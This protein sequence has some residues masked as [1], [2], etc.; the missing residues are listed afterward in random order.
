MKFSLSPFRSGK[1]L[2]T[3]AIRIILVACTLSFCYTSPSQAQSLRSK[4]DGNDKYGYVEE[5]STQ[6]VIPPIYDFAYSFL[7]MNNPVAL[8]RYQ[9]KYG[10]INTSGGFVIQP[11]Y[12]DATSFF[13]GIAIVKEGDT[14]YAIDLN[15]K[16]ISPDFADLKRS[17][18]LYW[19]KESDGSYYILDANFN[20]ISNRK[21]ESLALSNMQL[22]G[23]P[24]REVFF[25]WFSENGKKG[26]CDVKGN[27]V[28]PA[29]YSELHT[30]DY[31]YA[32]GYKKCDK[33]NIT[34]DHFQWI[35]KAKDASTGKFGV[36]DL[37]GNT[38]VP[39]TFKDSYKLYKGTSRYY[40]KAFLPLFT[41][42]FET[43]KQSVADRLIPPYTEIATANSQLAEV[44]P[45]T[46]E[47][48]SVSGEILAVKELK[49]A[50]SSKKQS[51]GKGQKSSDETKSTGR[52]AFFNGDQQ[53][54]TAYTEIIPLGFSYL[55][56]DT[57]GKMGIADAMGTEIV[58][59]EYDDI[60]I[61]R[62][63]ED[64][65]HIL[66]AQKGEESGLMSVSGSILTPIE[67]SSIFL[68][69]NQTGVA[70]KEGKYFLINAATGKVVSSRGYDDIDNYTSND[71]I[72]AK[73]AGFTTTLSADGQENPRIVDQAFQIAYDTPDQE[74]QQKYDRYMLC[75][76][77]CESNS[78][79]GTVLNNVG[80]LYMTLND[81]E[82]AIAYYQKAQALGNANA[83]ENLKNINRARRLEMIQQI[84]QAI[85]EVGQAISANSGM[86]PIN[87]NN[88]YTAAAYAADNGDVQTVSSA[89][90]NNKLPYETY[91]SIYDRWERNAKSCYESLTLLGTREKKDG[92][93]VRGSANGTWGAV[94]YTGMKQNLRKAQKEMR[95]TRI[96][97]RRDGYDIPQSNYE[98]VSVS[99]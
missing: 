77:L 55:L 48:I 7:S 82:N 5:G 16:K 27:D 32:I 60:N 29:N 92:E 26:I 96:K 93:D 18:D 41:T 33:D 6:W 20:H 98:T 4:S 12:D 14:F 52:M 49:P 31:Y 13:H 66:L 19:G 75:L 35:L 54:G 80:A 71:Q 50:A 34:S 38:V 37:L 36:L 28:I 8:V 72:T 68:P 43:F 23:N 24:A 2:S 59:C 47:N 97:A 69:N 88:D 78:D 99:F 42:N 15:E 3:Q 11:R 30:E 65:N 63:S 79:R 62:V 64:G 74:A 21:F 1:G 22:P 85:A 76:S 51:K 57:L 70:L 84:G 86:T 61:W 10:Y 17:G 53:V 89:S 94:S 9:G 58:K 56:T 83:A 90:D 46:L 87:T 44:H 95:E 40:K 67:Y 45:Q 39:C 73:L 25:F 91:K 81:E